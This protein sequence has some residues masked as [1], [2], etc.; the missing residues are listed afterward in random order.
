M[1]LTQFECRLPFVYLYTPVR[2]VRTFV[3]PMECLPGEREGHHR[4]C[5]RFG[6]PAYRRLVLIPRC[7]F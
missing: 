1:R 7:V 6:H 5:V 3:S 2:I 4:W